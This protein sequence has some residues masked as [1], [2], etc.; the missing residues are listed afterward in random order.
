M[1]LIWHTYSCFFPYIP[2][3]GTDMCFFLYLT[4]YNYLEILE[5]RIHIQ[6]RSLACQ[7]KALLYMLQGDLY[8]MDNAVSLQ[9]EFGE[10]WR[11]EFKTCLLLGQL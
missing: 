8:L 11:Q 7:N 1:M 9:P 4:D 2:V 10:T 5:M 3:F 6:Q